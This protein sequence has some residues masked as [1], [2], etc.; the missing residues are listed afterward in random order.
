[1]SNASGFAASL[2]ISFAIGILFAVGMWSAPTRVDGPAFC[3]ASEKLAALDLD[4]RRDVAMIARFGSACFQLSRQAGLDFGPGLQAY[5]CNVFLSRVNNEHS[6]AERGRLRTAFGPQLRIAALASSYEAG[7]PLAE[8]PLLTG[9]GARFIILS[10]APSQ[11]D[12]VLYTV[13]DLQQTLRRVQSPSGALD[14]LEYKGLIG[15][16]F[17]LAEMDMRTVCTAKS[18]RENAGGWT[19]LGLEMQPNCSSTKIVDYRVDRAG[20]VHILGYQ[21]TDSD[22]ICID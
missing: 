13:E 14:M 17:V 21:D 10:S 18:V 3:R 11:V 20:N 5:D 8:V 15:H 12:R 9:V 2:R 4:D 22:T 19:I 7:K 1:M 6:R 16:P